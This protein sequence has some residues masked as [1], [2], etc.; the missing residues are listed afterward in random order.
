MID[1]LTYFW[2]LLKAS[3]FSTGGTGNL[4]TLHQDLIRRGWADE[5]NF[6]ESLAIGQIGPGPSGLWVIGLGYLT[7]GIPGSLLATVAICIPAMVVLVVNGLYRRIGA[8]PATAGFIRGISLAIVGLSVV[9]LSTLMSSTGINLRNG[10]IVLAALVLASFRRI[11]I[12]LILLLA[13]LA[14]IALYGG[15]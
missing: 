1:P 2:L 11:P 3:L 14:G 10:L 13:G 8:H 4:P 9:V 5:Q 7:Y 12:F 15:S 6:A